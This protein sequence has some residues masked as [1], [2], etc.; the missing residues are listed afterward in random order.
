[1]PVYDFKCLDC[2]KTF[3]I[4]LRLKDYE[5]KNF[6]CPNCGG[7]NLQQQISPFQVKTSKKS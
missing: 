1:M 6:Q 5:D 4:T 2:Q 3:T 7:K